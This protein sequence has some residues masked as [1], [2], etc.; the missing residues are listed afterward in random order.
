MQSN[1]QTLGRPKYDS[2]F[3]QA[4]LIKLFLAYL[5][6]SLFITVEHLTGS[7]NVVVPSNSFNCKECLATLREMYL[8]R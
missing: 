2:A 8:Q 5:A 6:K 4:E 3:L 7:Y 1:V